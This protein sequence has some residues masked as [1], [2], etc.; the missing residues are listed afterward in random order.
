VGDRRD[1]GADV[2]GNAADIVSPQLHFPGVQ[3]RPNT[4]AN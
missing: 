1:A 4:D 2:D 3:A